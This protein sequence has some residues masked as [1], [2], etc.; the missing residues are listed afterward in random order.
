M[1][2][3]ES[4]LTALFLVVLLLAAIYGPEAVTVVIDW[5]RQKRTAAAATA[6]VR[7]SPSNPH[8]H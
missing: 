8:K 2:P 5:L 7:R 3:E 1:T 4:P 6:T